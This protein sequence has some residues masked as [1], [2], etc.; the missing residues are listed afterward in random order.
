MTTTSN[1][2]LPS[3]PVRKLDL[4][5]EGDDANWV[6]DNQVITWYFNALSASFPGAEGLFIRVAYK[7]AKK[8]KDPALQSR[9]R[10]FI[11]QEAQHSKQHNY[12]NRWLAELGF[13]MESMVGLTNTRVGE[14]EN[15]LSQTQAV[16]LV[17]AL[18]HYTAVV[19]RFF[20]KQ[21]ELLAS[22]PE[23]ARVAL[24]W[25]AIE[26][27]EHKAICFDL[28]Q[29]TIGDEKERRKA[30]VMA[31]WGFTKMTLRS[32]YR[33]ARAADTLPSW[34]DIK[35]GAAFFFGQQGLVPMLAAEIRQYMKPDF[36]PNQ[37][38]DSALIDDWRQKYPD[39][40]AHTYAIA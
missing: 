11:G 19:A 22:S 3:I 12:M 39:V 4:A 1:I 31:T 5:F 13:P 18:E 16:A 6:S 38:D 2:D 8:I 24:T 27:I 15:R 36:H 40:S 20:L 25:H 29:E 9:V 23:A 33:Q 37:H 17:A 30:M 35:G 34:N 32:L 26:E 14:L 7:Q 10:G 21:P 28:Y